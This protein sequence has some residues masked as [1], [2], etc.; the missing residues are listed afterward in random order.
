[1][2]FAKKRKFNKPESK[3]NNIYSQCE[4]T[5]KV[6]LPFNCV[7]KNLINTFE[8]TISSQIGG[9]C[10]VE[11]YVKANSIRVITHSSGLIKG[12]LIEFDVVFNCEIFYPVA[13]MHLNCVALDVT[14]AGIRAESNEDSASPFVLFVARDHNYNDPDFNSI[15]PGD[16]FVANVIAQRFELNDKK[17]SIIAN[18]LPNSKEKKLPQ[19]QIHDDNGPFTTKKPKRQ[20]K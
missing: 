18:V 8:T 2:E 14:K 10:I 4:I 3:S 13:N 17:I 16:K 19:L 7:G 1:M 12:D 9:K 6:T 11:G 20:N 5:K 15:E